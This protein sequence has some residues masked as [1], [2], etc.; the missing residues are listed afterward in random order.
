MESIYNY[1][2]LV[3]FYEEKK[4]EIVLDFHP[5]QFIS[6]IKDDQVC[7]NNLFEGP[8][9]S[10]E[11]EGGYACSH[12]KKLSQMF[13]DF[14]SQLDTSSLGVEDQSVLVPVKVI[15]NASYNLEIKKEDCVSASYEI[16][17]ELKK[18][19]FYKKLKDL[20]SKRLCG[21]EQ[22]PGETTLIAFNVWLNGVLINWILETVFE[23][24]SLPKHVPQLMTAFECTGAGY[25]VIKKDFHP[26]SRKKNLS[27]EEALGILYQIA[28]IWQILQ[29][30]Y[31]IHGSITIDKLNYR[32]EPVDYAISNGYRVVSPITLVIDGFHF[33]SIYLSGETRVIPND[34][35]RNVDLEISSQRF[36]PIIE[37]EKREGGSLVYTTGYGAE[38]FFGVMRYS[39]YP[40]FGGSYDIYSILTSLLSWCPFK[41]LVKENPKLKNLLS[42]MFVDGGGLPTPSEDNITCSFKIGNILGNKKLYCDSISRLMSLLNQY[43]PLN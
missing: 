28:S 6:F 4:R 9:S 33:S 35:G 12:C 42:E 31:F 7:E 11:P 5:A 8:F 36:S 38:Y 17:S 39:G 29:S 43:Y 30:K 22:D 24:L 40:L 2:D 20:S 19:K 25:K 16:K 41:G 21:L 23:L 15:K 32:N 26:L 27:L 37:T 13:Y 34:R 10:S 1:N 18:T 14:F 3:E